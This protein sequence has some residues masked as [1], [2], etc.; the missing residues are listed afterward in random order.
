MLKFDTGGSVKM[1]YALK[2]YIMERLIVLGIWLLIILL[3]FFSE[4]TIK[5][6]SIKCNDTKSNTDA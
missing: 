6:V 5:D 3:P 4:I 2:N 1:K